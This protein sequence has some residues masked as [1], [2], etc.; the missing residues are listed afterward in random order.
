MQARRQE[1]QY[2][3]HDALKVWFSLNNANPNR[4]K[5]EINIAS[6]TTHSKVTVV[7]ASEENI[8]IIYIYS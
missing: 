5:E 7:Y 8:D 1:D 4:Q 6:V 3:K 2:R